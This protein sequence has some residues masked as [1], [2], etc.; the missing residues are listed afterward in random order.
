LRDKN[1]HAAFFLTRTYIRDNPELC[2]RMAAEGHVVANHSWRHRSFPT[3]TDEEIEEEL[4]ETARFYQETTGYTMEPFFRPPAGE[5]S[6]RTLALTQTHGYTTVFWS[7]THVDWLV[8]DQP[9][10]EAAFQRVVGNLHN[11]AV[12]LL[13]AVSESNTEALPDIIDAAR[14]MGYE[15]GSLW[16]LRGR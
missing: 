14:G 7:L 15:F 12:I 1:V 9:G 8:D 4:L 16:E 5:Y 3:L 2:R 10:K 13:H 11:G 6:A